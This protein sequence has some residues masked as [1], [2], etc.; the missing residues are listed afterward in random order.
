MYLDTL[1]IHSILLQDAILAEETTGTG[2]E[3][4]PDAVREVLFRLLEQLY[5]V[6]QELSFPVPQDLCCRLLDM[7]YKV[8]PRHVFVQYISAGVL[9]VTPEFAMRLL[10]DHEGCDGII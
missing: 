9:R 7:G 6:L 5:N 8:L 4:G 3:S 10:V 2:D 1:A